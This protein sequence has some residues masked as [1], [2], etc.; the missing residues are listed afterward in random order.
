MKKDFEL[1]AVIR[2]RYSET[3]QMGIVYNANYLDWFEVARTE[4]CR[5]W[6]RPYSEWEKEGFMIPVAE[7]HCRYKRPAHYD[8]GIEI[9]CRADEV[10]PH[11]MRF[12]YRV[13]NSDGKKLLAEGWTKH[14]CTDREGKLC[15]KPHPFYEWI[16]SKVEKEGNA[17]E[18]A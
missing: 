10:N 15:K 1:A 8:D 16:L 12:E 17:G 5:S 18:E 4:L 7:A 14:A 9:R 11:S 6:G 3:D 2:V 13:L